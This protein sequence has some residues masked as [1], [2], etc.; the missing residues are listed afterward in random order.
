[1]PPE[2]ELWLQGL[3]AGRAMRFRPLGGSMAPFL[4]PGDIVNICPG[5]TCRAGDIVLWQAGE[6]L[7][8]HRVVAKKN[9]RIITK[10]DSLR[11]LDAPV[12]REQILGRAVARERQGRLHSLDH[13]GVRFLGLAWC[14]TSW[15][16]GLVSFLASARRAL[17]KAALGPTYSSGCR[18]PSGG[19]TGVYR[20]I[21]IKVCD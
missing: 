5:E 6:V 1:M 19:P 15:I 18:P 8:L 20:N 9:G 2:Q 14:L 12:R 13:L 17:R 4:R 10:G 16:P 21:R 11:S 7:I 3:S